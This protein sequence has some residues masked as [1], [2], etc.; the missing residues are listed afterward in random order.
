M[1]KR[2]MCL[3]IG[4]SLMAV[5]VAFIGWRTLRGPRISEVSYEQIEVGMTHAD[6]DAI[7]GVPMGDY[8]SAESFHIIDLVEARET[9]RVRCVTWTGPSHM[10]SVYFHSS[11]DRVVGK[12]LA[13]AVQV[14]WWVQLARRAGV[15]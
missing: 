11:D 9:D 3:A 12:H 14:P 7:I 1:R 15:R 5:C 13:E 6:V 4:L 10:I 2:R 8:G